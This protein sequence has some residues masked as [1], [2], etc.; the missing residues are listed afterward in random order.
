[1]GR[2]S[3]WWR[4][5]CSSSFYQTCLFVDVGYV[6]SDV[7]WDARTRTAFLTLNRQPALPLLLTH[8]D[9]RRRALV[10]S[11]SIFVFSFSRVQQ[12]GHAIMWIKIYVIYNPAKFVFSGLAKGTAYPALISLHHSDFYYL[13]NFPYSATAADATIFVIDSPDRSISIQK[14]Y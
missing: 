11:P 4:R 8:I 14:H 9:P 1:M 13:S 12:P 10:L 6:V 2:T 5:C 3:F 7:F